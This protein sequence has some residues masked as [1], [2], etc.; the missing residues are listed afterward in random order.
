MS[1]SLQQGLLITLEGID[2]C[3]K[4]LQ[5]NLLERNLAEK[6]VPV[7]LFREPG[8]TLLSERIRDL[9]L[10]RSLGPIDPLAELLLYSAARSQLVREK[11]RPALKEGKVVICDRFYDSSTAYQGYGRGLPIQW[12]K[13][14]NEMATGG[15]K[16]DLTFIIDLE[17]EQAL[18]RGQRIGKPW[19]RMEREHAEFYRRVREGYLKIA[20]EE[21]ER[22]RVINGKQSIDQIQKE[23]WQVM[24]QKHLPLIPV[25]ETR[26]P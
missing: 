3:G 8:G 17:P 7:V 11:I 26:K 5:A 12:V 14:I 15:L 25:Q 13:R 22:V 10:D 6:E 20:Q 1:R 24:E 23:I 18:E 19:D 21:P 16:P 4:S 2:F 9:L